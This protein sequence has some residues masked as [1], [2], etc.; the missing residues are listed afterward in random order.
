GGALPPRS[1]HRT[2][3]AAAG[4]W[5]PSPSPTWLASRHRRKKG[6]FAR[7]QNGGVVPHVRPVDGGADHLRI[8][9]RVGIF[10][11]ATAEPGHEIGDRGDARRRLD[12]LLRLADP[13]PPPRE[14]AKLPRSD[15]GQNRHADAAST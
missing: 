1:R 15:L 3:R 9:E 7:A 6:D 5:R 13:P 4:W 2:A 11:T 8:L 12:L 10:L 14:I